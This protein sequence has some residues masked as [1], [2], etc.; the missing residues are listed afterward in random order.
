MI[1]RFLYQFIVLDFK[2][3]FPSR[4][5]FISLIV[6]SFASLFIF[7]YTSKAIG[8]QFNDLGMNYFTFILSGE[9][10][11]YLA[12]ILLVFPLEQ[13]K[14][15]KARGVFDFILATPTKIFTLILVRSLAVIPRCLLFVCLQL[16]LASL[17][18]DFHLSIF[19]YLVMIFFPIIGFGLFFSLGLIAMSFFLI[20]GRGASSIGYLT[21]FISIFS[22]A[23]FPLSVL[24][25][26]LSFIGSFSPYAKIIDAIRSFIVMGKSDVLI[27][28]AGI[29]F[30]WTLLIFL[31]GFYLL[32]FALK[33]YKSNPNR[34]TFDL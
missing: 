34:F 27:E 22:G 33:I 31:I 17:F 12:S 30:I 24:P 9:I 21:T 29:L 4:I 15:W 7:Y 11:L 1:S 20:T 25:Q 18:F 26:W 6:S 3:Y 8:D 23:Y 19:Q 14:Q 28:T 5:S 16:L 13:I 10:S 32:R 2:K